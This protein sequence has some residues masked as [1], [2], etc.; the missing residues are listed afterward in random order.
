M[1]FG[2]IPL[3]LFSA[4]D[5]HLSSAIGTV[6]VC[7]LSIYHM[8]VKWSAEQKKKSWTP[9]PLVAFQMHSPTSDAREIHISNRQSPTQL[10]IHI[11]NMYLKY[12]IWN[13]Q[14]RN[15]HSP[16]CT[17]QPP[18][19]SEGCDSWLVRRWSCARAP[20]WSCARALQVFGT[21]CTLYTIVDQSE[22]S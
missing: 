9:N 13:T 17:V 19:S 15:A 6:Q 14:I 22:I 11:C 4:C 3:I 7:S 8:E 16:V 5:I 20:R 21:W 2:C 10:Q 18:W 12:K 1:P